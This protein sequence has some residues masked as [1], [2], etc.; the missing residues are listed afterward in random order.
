MTQSSDTLQI[1]TPENVTFDYDV[2]GIGSRFLSAL[3][4]TLLMLLLQVIVY[5]TLYLIGVQMGGLFSDS[6]PFWLV[7]ILSL[8][9]FVFFW[10]YYIFFEIL[11]NGQTPG[12]RWVGL[13]VIR[14]DGTP[15]TAAEVVI[16][17]LVRLI[18][19]L[20][21]A[22]G[23][24]V[25]TMFVN[26]KSRRLGDLAAGTVVVHDR[27]VHTLDELGGQRH[28][29]LGMLT[30]SVPLPEGFPLERL[31]NHDIEVMEGFLTRR[32]QLPNHKQLALQIMNS[33]YTRLNLPIPFPWP[34]PPEDLL[35]SIY[36]A[37]KGRSSE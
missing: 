6:A 24:G 13:R 31:K 15:V 20:P 12:K 17:N 18:D 36:A 21:T 28:P 14:L 10:G 23:V 27:A 1:D 3:V 22:Y 26:D 34:Y 25:V 33:L 5:G 37:V 29:V 7:A 19:L 32:S 30:A 8:V 4:D 2:A 35:V 9:A 16:R 11:W